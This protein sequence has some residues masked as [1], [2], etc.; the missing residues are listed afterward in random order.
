MFAIGGVLLCIGYIIFF[1]LGAFGIIGVM[2]QKNHRKA[3]SFIQN[4]YEKIEVL[5]KLLKKEIW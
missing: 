3:T 2:K 5:H 4:E 1:P